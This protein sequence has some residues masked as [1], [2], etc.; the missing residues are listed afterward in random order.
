VSCI[1]PWCAA[2]Q[3]PSPCTI[4][5]DS[6]KTF[7][8]GTHDDGR[9]AGL[10]FEKDITISMRIPSGIR[11]LMVEAIGLGHGHS[12]LLKEIREQDIQQYVCG[13]LAAA[14]LLHSKALSDEFVALNEQPTS[15]DAV[16]P[17]APDP[18]TPSTRI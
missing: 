3:L 2:H 16:D 9:S 15:A 13:L 11:A 8:H 10:P 17:S 4:H 14:L 12:D 18:G 6:P 5:P 1:Y 7:A